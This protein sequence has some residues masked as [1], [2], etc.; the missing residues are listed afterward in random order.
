MLEIKH[1]R[2]VRIFLA[3]T[4]LVVAQVVWWTT[5]F[6]KDVEVISKLKEEN[7]ALSR[8]SET[9]KTENIVREAFHRRFMFLSESSFFVVLAFIGFYLLY[10]ALKLEEK[11]RK[12]QRNFIEVLTHESKTPL[13]A[14]K[15]RLESI[16]EKRNTDPVLHQELLLSL[17]EVRRLISVFEKALNLNRLER[18]VYRFET[19]YLADIVKEVVHRL[20]PLFKSKGVE[21]TLKLDPEAC[22]RGDIHTLEASLQNLLEN[23]ALYNHNSERRIYVELESRAPH[24]IL[25]IEDNGP[26]IK[27]DEQE[28]IFERFYRGTSSRRVPG[29]GLGLY[30]SKTIIE[31]H[32]GM[33]RLVRGDETGSAFEIQLP[34]AS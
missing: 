23:A 18:Q 25:W 4:F 9:P 5:A 33:I 10:R 2:W 17:E 6:L 31:A 34:A 19:L 1:R 3:V 32:Q 16:L 7:A 21:I 24:T 27:A 13:T 20:D 11:S 14:L 15:L 28:R 22:V 12:T 30:I 29:T 26:G 8:G